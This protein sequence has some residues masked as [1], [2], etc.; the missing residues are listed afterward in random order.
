MN[1]PWAKYGSLIG[2]GVLTLCRGDDPI[3]P[4]NPSGSN[5]PP[6]PPQ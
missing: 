6:N 2:I 4:S 1:S 5:N 3:S